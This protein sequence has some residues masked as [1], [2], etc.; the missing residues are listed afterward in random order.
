MAIARWIGGMGAAIALVAPSAWAADQAGTVSKGGPEVKYITNDRYEGFLY[1][2]RGMRFLTPNLYVGLMAYGTLPLI[3][4]DFAPAFGYGGGLAG[5]EG[6]LG[7]GVSYD[8]NL[9]AGLTNDILDGTANPARNQLTFEPSVAVGLPV[10]FLKATRVSLCAGYLVLPWAFSNS[11][12]T[13]GLRW[14]TKMVSRPV[15]DD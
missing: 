13:I 2:G 1:G 9:H 15:D 12:P 8:L 11:G 7:A 5:W 10:P 3:G 14:E 6:R 4:K